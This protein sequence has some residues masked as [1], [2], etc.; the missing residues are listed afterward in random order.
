MIFIRFIN[1]KQVEAIQCDSSPGADWTVAS[2]DFSWDK[3]YKLVGNQVV[4]MT[5]EDLATEQL[6]AEKQR[7]LEILL[8][9]IQ[10][11]LEPYVGNSLAEIQKQTAQV[12]AAQAALKGD[13]QAIASLTPL[14]EIHS[15]S[16]EEISTQ[17]LE[18]DAEH[19]KI[20]ILCQAFQDKLDLKIQA[21]ETLEE[22]QAYPEIFRTQFNQAIGGS[23]A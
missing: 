17:I 16:V 7:I 5:A 3:R 8:H 19:R 9:E 15:C 20:L 1:D 13:S 11:F 12:Q 14:A 22:L 21:I 18:Q 23:D 6:E 10:M 2:A 4:E